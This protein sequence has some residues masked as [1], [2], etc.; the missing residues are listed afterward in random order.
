MPTACYHNAFLSTDTL[1]LAGY[2]LTDA[3]TLKLNLKP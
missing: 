3:K 2:V 1:P